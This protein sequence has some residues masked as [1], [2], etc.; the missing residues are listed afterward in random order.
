MKYTYVATCKSGS[1]VGNQL[2]NQTRLVDPLVSDL[3][4]QGLLKKSSDTES[5]DYVKLKPTINIT[6]VPTRST[7]KL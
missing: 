3:S 7:A 6:D 2:S 1:G 5:K 4:S